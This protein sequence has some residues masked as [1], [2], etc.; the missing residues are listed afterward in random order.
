MDV[1]ET[2]LEALSAEINRLEDEIKI[3]SVDEADK[4]RKKIRSKKHLVRY[5]INKSQ[6]NPPINLEDISSK[7]DPLIKVLNL[8]KEEKDRK[9]AKLTIKFAKKLLN[10]I[11][12]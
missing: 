2:K 5:Y 8:V 4:L 9:N 6:N 11:V 3:A 1:V 7:I 12:L 10:A